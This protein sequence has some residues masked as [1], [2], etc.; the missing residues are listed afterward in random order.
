[1][2]QT[3]CSLARSQPQHADTASHPLI[4]NS[5]RPRRLA[6]RGTLVHAAPAKPVKGTPVA[7][8]VFEDTLIIV[9]TAS[10]HGWRRH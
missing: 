5:R 7:I 4:A 9:E 3:A 8:E 2:A 1:M 10:F 6:L